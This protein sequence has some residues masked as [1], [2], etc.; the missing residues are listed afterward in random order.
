MSEAT[1]KKVS[2]M[3]KKQI[4][5]FLNILQYF[6]NEMQE[7]HSCFFLEK[8]AK[9]TYYKYRKRLQNKHLNFPNC[10]IQCKGRKM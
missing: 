8:V 1:V 4:F 7:N 2:M 9:R 6:A 5:F 3:I 10:T